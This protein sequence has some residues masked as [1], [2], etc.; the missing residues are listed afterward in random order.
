MKHWSV[1]LIYLV[2]ACGPA[3]PA[4]PRAIAIAAAL[5]SLVP[6]ARIG[7]V[8]APVAERLNLPVAPYVGY[9]SE[10]YRA[11]MGVRGVALQV[12]ENLQSATDRPSRSARIKG[13]VLS[14]ASA[15]AAD[16]MLGFLTRKIGPP[17]RSCYAPVHQPDRAA[18]YFW[19]DRSPHGV[20]LVVRVQD[21]RRSF[22]AF[23]AVEPDSNSS[24]EG[25]L[26]PSPCDAA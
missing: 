17:D 9:L 18:L 22:V 11:A 8:A 5:D 26:T 14:F 20:L 7:G 21:L 1:A 12:N 24:F 25:A 2:T 10:D 16:S 6:G 4:S 19:P 3:A 23:D 15:A 13:V